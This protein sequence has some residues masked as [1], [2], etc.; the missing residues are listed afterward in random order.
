MGWQLTPGLVVQHQ[1]RYQKFRWFKCLLCISLFPSLKPYGAR[2]CSY[3]IYQSCQFSQQSFY[4]L[5]MWCLRAI[6]KTHLWKLTK[7]PELFLPYTWSWKTLKL[8]C[9]VQLLGQ[10]TDITGLFPCCKTQI[11]QS[12]LFTRAGFS[13]PEI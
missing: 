5:W 13:F 12:M 7:L 6:R 3:A 8:K 9:A 2:V 11:N 1:N 10:Y 4:S